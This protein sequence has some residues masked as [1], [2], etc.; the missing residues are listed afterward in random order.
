MFREKF[1]RRLRELRLSRGLSQEQLAMIVHT[2]TNA[3]G[4]YETGKRMP[5]EEILENLYAYFDVSLDYLF[6]FSDDPNPYK[7]KEIDVFA[8]NEREGFEILNN[9]E[10][11]VLFRKGDFALRVTDKI[12][13]SLSPFYFL[14]DIL[15]FEKKAYQKNTTALMYYER[16]YFLAKLVKKGNVFFAEFLNPSFEGIKVPVNAA[17]LTGVM[18]GMIRE[19][20]K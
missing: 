18:I 3:I 20:K 10:E 19:L 4:M 17:D 16:Q 6:G 5:R 8:I 13:D 7:E 9:T 15:V 11:T 2:S 14:N 1:S 12:A